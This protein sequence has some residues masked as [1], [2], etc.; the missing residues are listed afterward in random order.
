MKKNTFAE[1][2]TVKEFLKQSIDVIHS[3]LRARIDEIPYLTDEEKTEKYNE[4]VDPMESSKAQIENTDTNVIITL[5][6][7]YYEAGSK[8]SFKDALRIVDEVMG[9]DDNLDAKKKLKE[10][11][12]LRKSTKI[13]N[14]SNK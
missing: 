14:K 9:N 11:L 3:Q 2:R 1:V 4:L 5:D 7:I 12:C 10:R 13:W 8:Y 6:G